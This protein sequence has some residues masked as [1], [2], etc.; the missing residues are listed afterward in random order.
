MTCYMKSTAIAFTAIRAMAAFVIAPHWTIVLVAIIIIIIVVAVARALSWVEASHRRLH[1]QARRHYRWPRWPRRC[2]RRTPLCQGA[3][4]RSTGR[5]SRIPR[6]WTY[7]VGTTHPHTVRRYRLC[8]RLP[9][10]SLVTPKRVMMYRTHRPNC[11][12]HRMKDAL[13][14]NAMRTK[15]KQAMLLA[16]RQRTTG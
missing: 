8:V 16:G 13:W 2:R 4:T 11:V 15:K 9:A 7:M 12:P 3:Q 1:P 6:P 5:C 10:L 14:S